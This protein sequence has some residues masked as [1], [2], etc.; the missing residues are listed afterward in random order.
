VE[1]PGRLRVGLTRSLFR[2]DGSPAFDFGLEL[3]DGRSDL[4]W[5]VIPTDD[6]ELPG[7]LL[8]RYD[9]IIV[10]L[11]G[12]VT[13]RSLE[14][15]ERLR[16]VARVGV[17][18]D[19]VDVDACTERG[20]LLTTTP[21]GVRRPMAAAAITFV[22][23][24]SQHLLPRD[25]LCRDGRWN[26]RAGYVGVGLAGRT[27]G[28]VGLGNIGR[29]VARLAEPFELVRIAYDPYVSEQQAAAVGCRLTSLEE[30]MRTADFVVV[31]C[32]LVPE[33]L[34][35]ID[36]ERIALMRPEAFLVNVAR[37]PIVDQQALTEALAARRIAGAGLDVFED[38]PLAADDPLTR[39]DNVIMTAHSLGWTDHC[40][41]DCGVSAIRAVIDLAEGR[42]PE[43]VVNRAALE[44]ARWTS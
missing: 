23:A 12:D 9:A 20:V 8:A 15:A 22:L 27:L 16:L 6:E 44:H 37:G 43:H 33:T 29:E 28:L 7:E 38:E 40:F 21:D 42:R 34:R 4:E 30:L 2:A 13:A 39:L 32:A 24:L 25:R 14:G 3:L 36:A 17:G 19:S 26:E 1:R 5:E 10:E 18:Y 35:L 11:P 31:T 41:R